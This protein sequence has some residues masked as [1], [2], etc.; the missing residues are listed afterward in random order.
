V[1][2]TETCDADAPNLV[3][4]VATVPATTNDVEMTGAIQDDLAARDLLP[5]EQFLDAGYVSAQHL[6]ASAA[7]HGIELVGPALL[8]TSWQAAAEGGFDL[9][10]FT[11]DWERRTVT[12]PQGKIS[13]SW[14]D[15]KRGEYPFSQV[16]FGRADCQDCPVRARCT[17]A[18][19]MPRQLAVR[20]REEHVTLQAARERQKTATFQARYA[21]R[22]GI[23]GTL[24][25]GIQSCGLRRARYRGPTSSTWR[26]PPRSTC[27]GS[28]TGGPAR[29]VRAHDA[30]TSPTWRLLREWVNQ[31]ANSVTTAYAFTI[32]AIR[33][34]RCCTQKE[35]TLK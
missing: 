7:T 27:N 24:A 34:A 32:C 29:P 6:V 31:L 10:C 2:L 12:C 3:S 5:G 18:A 14:H 22:A 20:P 17:R 26:P 1:H 4:Q 33:T 15:V 8:D 13:R 35:P 21:R 11:I 9:T 19:T 30:R 25:Q 28:T 16:K 23:E